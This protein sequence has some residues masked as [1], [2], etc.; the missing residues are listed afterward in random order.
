MLLHPARRHLRRL[1]GVRLSGASCN[2]GFFQLGKSFFLV[3]GRWSSGGETHLDDRC[4]SFRLSEVQVVFPKSQL[5]DEDGGEETAMKANGIRHSTP[6]QK[7]IRIA[8]AALSGTLA[9]IISVSIIDRVRAAPE[10]FTAIDSFVRTMTP[11]LEGESGDL[12]FDAASNRWVTR[13]E[14]A[15]E[16]HAK[17]FA[18]FK[19]VLDAHDLPLLKNY[20]APT[21]SVRDDIGKILT[22]LESGDHKTR[23]AIEAAATSIETLRDDA[24]VAKYVAKYTG[25]NVPILFDHFS[26]SRHELLKAAELATAELELTVDDLVEV[27][28]WD[29]RSINKLDQGSAAAIIEKA[30]LACRK[31]RVS[32]VMI[33]AVSPISKS[34]EYVEALRGRFLESENTARDILTAIASSPTLNSSEFEIVPRMLLEYSEHMHDR[35]IKI[36]QDQEIAMEA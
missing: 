27:S 13:F 31:S 7:I 25:D 32:F 23:S 4:A 35:I 15:Y 19:H 9:F 17:L 20:F 30:T 29:G 34:K 1:L 6:Q 2:N 18:D 28:G 11:E 14:P 21:S 33:R 3:A 26:K 22:A 8:V 5:H 24:T 12:I 10:V 16:D 36:K